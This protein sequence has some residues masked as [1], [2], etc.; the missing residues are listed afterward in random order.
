MSVYATDKDLGDIMICHDIV[1]NQTVRITTYGWLDTER[2]Q[3][4]SV[5]LDRAEAEE[6]FKSLRKFLRTCPTC[7]HN[8]P[9][10]EPR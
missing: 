8:R 3:G 9:Y 5:E 6:V 2:D 4:Q 10:G 1:H 7:G